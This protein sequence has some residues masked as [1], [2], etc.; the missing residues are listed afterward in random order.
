MTLR[1]FCFAAALLCGVPA[2]PAQ[3]CCGPIAPEGR[4]L[5]AFLDH[6]GVEHLWRS[7]W[8]VDWRTGRIDRP[9]PG[10]PE[11]KTHCSAFVAAIAERLGVYILRPPQHPQELLANAQM[12][13]LVDRG[14]AAGWRPVATA[15]LAQSLANRGFLVVAAFINPN[16]HKPGHIAILRPSEKSLA[17]LDRDGPDETQAGA[18]NDLS[19]PL[20]I[21]FRHHPGAWPP[22]GSDAVRF[23]AHKVTRWPAS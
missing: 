2:A 17:A 21:G 18:T 3:P 22:G 6:S 12:R 5:A 20:R 9:A 7:G 23:F 16:P 4:A 1:S 10:G 8:R 19:V 13:W 15:V 14:A 11:A